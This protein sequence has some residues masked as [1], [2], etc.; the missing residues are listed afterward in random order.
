MPA[1]STIRAVRDGTD[2]ATED[3][4]APAREHGFNRVQE[5]Q[6]Y[7]LSGLAGAALYEAERLVTKVKDFA[8]DRSVDRDGRNCT[9][10]I[11]LPQTATVI[12]EALDCIEIAAES[13]SR[14]NVDIRDR[15]G[16]DSFCFSDPF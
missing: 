10:A 13:L 16:R 11:D 8:L 14:L 12:T 6:V 5:E 1:P 15:Q 4:P 3:K 7:Y 2:S 9:Q